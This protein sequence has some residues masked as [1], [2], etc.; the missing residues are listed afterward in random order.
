M[1]FK[2]IK[3]FFK[4][5]GRGELFLSLTPQQD[6][7][8]ESSVECSVSM[9]MLLICRPTHI[10]LSKYGWEEVGV[11]CAQH[12]DGMVRTAPLLRESS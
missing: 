5:H 6:N 7:G 4:N 8:V 10:W 1:Y 11:G 12:T 3:N 9:S 2:K